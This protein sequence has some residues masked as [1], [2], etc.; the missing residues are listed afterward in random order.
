[1]NLYYI[2]TILQG[3][4]RT[5]S[6]LEDNFIGI[7]WSGLGN[8]E[9]TPPEQWK[10]QLAKRYS[11]GETELTHTLATLHMFANLMQDGDYVL[12]RD[13]EWTYVGDIGDYYY[14]DSLGAEDELICHRRGITWLGRIPYAEL[15]DKVQ[16]L[17]NTPSILVKFEHPVSEAQLD[18]ALAVSAAAETS[19]TLT[20]NVDEALIQAALQVLKEALESEEEVLRVRAATAILQYAK[21]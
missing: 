20:A 14:D 18:R 11:L 10:E 8:L 21:P 7:P 16:A 13:E 17:W 6:F 12:I 2:Q 3:F 4:N 19:N 9:L 5:T 15:N 1:M